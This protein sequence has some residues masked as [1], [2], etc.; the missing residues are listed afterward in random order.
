MELMEIWTKMLTKLS[1]KVGAK[2]PATTHGINEWMCIYIPHISHVVSRRLT[3]LIEWDWTSAWKAPLPTELSMA[4]PWSNLPVSMTL[5]WKFFLTAGKPSTRPITAAKR[6]EK[7]KKE[8]R[9]KNFNRH[10]QQ[11]HTEKHG[12]HHPAKAASDAGLLAKQQSWWNRRLCWQEWHEKV[13]R[14]PERNLWS[15]HI[16]IITSMQTDL[17]SS[18]T[19]TRS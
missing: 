14:R 9:K 19:K 6:K 17:L 4:T 10:Q 12:Q 2:F 11:R 3:I 1:E 5:S 13:V 15:H 7:E 16:W 8:Q 18:L